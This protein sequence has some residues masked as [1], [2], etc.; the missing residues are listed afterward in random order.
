[1]PHKRWLVPLSLLL[2]V[3]QI[4]CTA[5][6]QVDLTLNT[7]LPSNTAVQP[8]STTV[9]TDT[10]E[11][12]TYPMQPEETMPPTT[13]STQPSEPT[14]TDP[15]VTQPTETVPP[16]T[17]LASTAPTETEPTA[18]VTAATVPPTTV[19]LYTELQETTQPATTAPIV[20]TTVPEGI[21]TAELR[22]Y[23]RSYAADTYGYEGDP[24]LDIANAGA[25][26][27]VTVTINTMQEGYAAVERAVDR[28]YNHDMGMGY[29]VVMEIDGVL[30]RA[31]INLYFEPTDDPN[32]FILWCF[33][34]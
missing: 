9:P 8:P 20:E 28:Q 32:T 24:S 26:P 16:V 11:E 4:G 25:F 30:C 6:R 18:A 33:Y 15:V 14:E 17:E 13:E 19:P 29:P 21:D 1:M 22:K 5:Q 3:M 23:G 7:T 27:G 31:K 2:L 34:R 10:T 12:M